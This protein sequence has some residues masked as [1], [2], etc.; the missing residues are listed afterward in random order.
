MLTVVIF[1]NQIKCSRLVKQNALQF[2]VEESAKIKI[3]E[4]T[5]NIFSVKAP[6]Y[7]AFWC[8]RQRV[9]K[10]PGVIDTGELLMT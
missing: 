3:P 7:Q 4:S 1:H 2:P 10:I 9:V 5:D 6:R 8:L